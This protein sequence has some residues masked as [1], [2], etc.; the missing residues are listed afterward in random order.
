MK[1]R[2]TPTAA[3]RVLGSA[4][5]TMSIVGSSSLATSG[6]RTPPVTVTGPI[7]VTVEPGDPSHDFIFSTS[8]M[9]LEGQGYI[10]EEFFIEGTANRYTR[11][12]LE[13]A[14]IVD[15][16]H[17]YKTRFV[18][19]RPTDPGRFNGTVVIEWNNVT[20]GRDLDIDWFQ[21]GEHFMRGG[22]AWIGL[23]AQRVGVD[24]LRGWSPTR[25]GSLD[26]TAGGTIDNDALS[27][28][29]LSAVAA[30]VRNPGDADVL[31]GLEVER[32]FATGHSQ[33]AG[34]LASYL[35]NV[36]PRD[37]VF[38]AVVVHGG[39]GRIRDDQ[40]VKVWKLMAETDM[41][42]RTGNR[43][44]D[45]DTFRQWEVAGSSHVD[46]FF[47]QESS[48]V[49]ALSDGRDPATAQLRDLS[50]ERPVYSRVPFRHVMHA[51]FDQ[52]VRWVDDGTSPATAP[53]IEAAPSGSATVF[54]RD[55]HGNARG[56][57]RLAA[58]AVPTATNTGINSG[59]GF[60]GLY[61]SHE[62]FDA[63]TLAALYPSHADYVAAVRAVV[64]E[65]LAA[66]YIVEHDA[67]ATIREAERSDIGRTPR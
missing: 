22:Y 4:L 21:M 38:D 59:S 18:V 25:Y 52:L 34:R 63:D 54:A 13:T 60:C 55:E 51:A 1:T 67:E 9:D 30:V 14:D 17:P 20:A 24:H 56:G 15:G 44:P 50:C 3:R 46:V 64:A 19:R 2:Y 10:E 61:G 41:R 27:Y 40:A 45:T 49:A 23:S 32:L 66:G 12:G 42:R 65:N 62:P 8:P 58:H 6:S 48:K 47:G 53:S 7:P 36:H 31:G 29:I 11:P 16:G 33:S 28:D 37:P 39:G 57:I 5:I 35:N 43:Q 26:V